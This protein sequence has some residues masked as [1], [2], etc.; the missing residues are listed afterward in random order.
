MRW[1]ADPKNAVLPNHSSVKYLDKSRYQDV[2]SMIE[3][4]SLLL[5]KGNVV[6][7]PAATQ[8]SANTFNTFNDLSFELGLG[9]AEDLH[10]QQ[11]GLSPLPCSRLALTQTRYRSRNTN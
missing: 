1:M 8:G 10:L 4:I 11:H 6:V 5:A 3:D 7:V 2:K 9:G